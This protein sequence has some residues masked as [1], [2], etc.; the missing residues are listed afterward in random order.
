MRFIDVRDELM[1]QMLV[2]GFDVFSQESE[3]LIR[4]TDDN[5]MDTVARIKYCI[6]DGYRRNQLIYKGN[7]IQCQT[8]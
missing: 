5:F 4:T 7:T 8:Y 1:E 6:Y 2:L 3:S